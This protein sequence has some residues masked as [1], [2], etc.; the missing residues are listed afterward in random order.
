[1]KNQWMW[2]PI[3]VLS[4]AVV[5]LALSIT[6]IPPPQFIEGASEHPALGELKFVGPASNIQTIPTAPTTPGA[7][8]SGRWASVRGTPRGA[9]SAG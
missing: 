5:V 4:I 1:M 3:A 6:I 7:R 2:I 8:V 9:R